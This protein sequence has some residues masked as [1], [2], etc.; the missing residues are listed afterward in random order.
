MSFLKILKSAKSVLRVNL[1]SLHVNKKWIITN[2]CECQKILAIALVF[3]VPNLDKMSLFL[4]STTKNLRIFYSGT[5]GTVILSSSPSPLVQ[6][7]VHY[8][9]ATKKPI[10]ALSESKMCILTYQLLSQNFKVFYLTAL[11]VIIVD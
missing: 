11:S 6:I 5:V 2:T 4:T 1:Y 9:P 3:I 10:T 8:L 7:L